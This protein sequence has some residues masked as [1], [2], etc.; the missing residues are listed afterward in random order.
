MLNLIIESKL[1]DSRYDAQSHA[2][3]FRHASPVILIIK[4]G[5]INIVQQ[6]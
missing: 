4:F 2:H 3:S 6:R 5:Y 1:Y